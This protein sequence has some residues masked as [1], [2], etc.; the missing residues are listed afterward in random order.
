MKASFNNATLKIWFH[1]STSRNISNVT[2]ITHEGNLM[3]IK[4]KDDRTYL[5][6][7]SNITLIEELEG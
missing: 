1:S 5:L 7:F 3:L 4:T 2:E 6:N